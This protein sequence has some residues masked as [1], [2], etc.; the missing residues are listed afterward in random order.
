MTFVHQI[1]FELVRFPPRPRV[2]RPVPRSLAEWNVD[3][4]DDN[5][6]DDAVTPCQN[7]LNDQNRFRK[8]LRGLDGGV[9]RILSDFERSFSA[10]PVPFKGFLFKSLISFFFFFFFFVSLVTIESLSFKWS[11]VRDYFVNKY[12]VSSDVHRNQTWNSTLRSKEI[13]TSE[14]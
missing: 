9:S 1:E 11:K 3:D 4:D 13:Q 8:I 6:D 10:I 14:K 12:L 5:D 7:Q 2:H